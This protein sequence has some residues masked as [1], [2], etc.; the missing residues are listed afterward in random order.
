MHLKILVVTVILISISN[1]VKPVYAGSLV[2]EIDYRYGVQG[3]EPSSS[4]KEGTTLYAGDTYKIEFTPKQDSYVY[5]LQTYA[6]GD[7]KELL[8]FSG[9]DNFVRAGQTYY[10]PGEKKSLKVSGGSRGKETIYFFPSLS[11][12]THVNE[13]FV[14]ADQG[15]EHLRRRNKEEIERQQGKI[16]GSGKAECK[17]LTELESEEACV[18]SY[19]FKP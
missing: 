7:Q 18:V 3:G 5:I 11:A 10:V 19:T 15:A 6:N 14:K 4:L 13:L 2:F 12:K 8:R 17:E 1:V 9:L 16:K